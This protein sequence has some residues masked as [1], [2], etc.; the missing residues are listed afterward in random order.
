VHILSS[1]EKEYFD[2]IKNIYGTV[3]KN[4]KH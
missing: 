1:V 2:N 3:T 4:G